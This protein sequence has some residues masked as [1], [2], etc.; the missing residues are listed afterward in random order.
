MKGAIWYV[1]SAIEDLDI[2]SALRGYLTQSDGDVVLSTTFPWD[3]RPGTIA[4][5]KNRVVGAKSKRAQF[6][7]AFTL[8]RADLAGRGLA[9]EWVGQA[10]SVLR[11]P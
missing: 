5:T 8:E 7:A 3:Q 4:G 6:N 2:A 10:I 1:R 9:V 11:L